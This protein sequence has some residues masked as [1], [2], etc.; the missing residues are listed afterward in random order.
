MADNL[1]SGSFRDRNGRVVRDNNRIFRTLSADAL[2][3]MDEAFKDGT[4]QFLTEHFSLWPTKLLSEDLT[5]ESVKQISPSS[6]ALEHE[7][8]SFISY[9]YEWSFLQL[10][11]AALLHL[12]LHLAALE[13]GYNLSDGS[14]FNVQFVNSKPYFIDTLSLIPYQ[15]GDYWEGYKQFCEQFLAP[16]LLSAKYGINFQ[17]WFRGELEGIPIGQLS[18]MARL[19]DYF[20]P[21]MLMHI[22]L[23][24]HLQQKYSDHQSNAKDNGKLSFSKKKLKNLLLSLRHSIS[25]LRPTN[26]ISTEWGDYENDN[27]YTKEESS[28]KEAL[29]RQFVGD[30]KAKV[31]WDL[32]CNAGQYSNAAL[33]GGAQ[34]AIGFDIDLSALEAGHKRAQEQ[35]LNFQALYFNAMNPSPNL[36]WRQNERL[37]LQERKNADLLLALAFIHHLVIGKNA[38]L[39]DVIEWLVKLAPYGIIEFVPKS[40][41]MIVRMLKTRADIFSD[42]SLENMITSLEKHASILQRHTSSQSGRELFFFKAHLS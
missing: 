40:D 23:H 16:L 19:R 1:V 22:I 25:S 28:N 6:R 5:P 37:G 31:V 41:P 3:T 4:I 39:P 8:I 21:T 34:I 7:L 15:E 30:I 13:R 12:N 2:K 24:S 9:P 17:S 20:S 36:G 27:S 18:K 26:Q 33:H 29:I 35:N 42:Y 14:A 38:L 32:G 11:E 10:K